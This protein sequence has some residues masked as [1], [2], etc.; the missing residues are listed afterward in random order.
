V[1]AI[2]DKIEVFIDFHIFA[3]LEFD[4]LIDY[5][6]ENLVKEKPSHGSLD[7]KFRK[8]ASATPIPCPESPMAKHNPNHDPFKEVKFI[9]HLFHIGFLVKQDVLYHPCSDLNL[10]PLA[11]KTLFSTM[12]ENQP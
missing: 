8:T 3:I 1:P 10:V 6:L 9:S 4:L 12:V 7:E 11:I 2:I 5:P